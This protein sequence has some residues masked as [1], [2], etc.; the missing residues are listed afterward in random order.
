MN[1]YTVMLLLI[2]SLVAISVFTR[3][4][5]IVKMAGIEKKRLLYEKMLT[6][7]RCTRMIYIKRLET[8]DN[9]RIKLEGLQVELKSEKYRLNTVRGSIREIIQDVRS[10][11]AP[12]KIDKLEANVILQKKITFGEH[13]KVLDNFR[14][15]YNK[16][17]ASFILIENESRIH[18]IKTQESCDKWEAQKS[19]LMSLFDELKGVSKVVDP[20]SMLVA[21]NN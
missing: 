14:L 10:R 9:F 21:A 6:E 20:R 18:L 11:L 5:S 8:S 13:W 3:I 2:M 19:V 4:F 17:L 12:S 7:A 16:K 15:K 1:Q